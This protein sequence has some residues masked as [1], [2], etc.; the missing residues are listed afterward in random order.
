MPK[1]EQ[2]LERAVENHPDRK[3]LRECNV[4][5]HDSPA[6]TPYYVL[7]M[8]MKVF[9]HGENE[10][11]E[12]TRQ[13]HEE[14]KSVVYTTHRE[15]AELKVSQVQTYGADQA[16]IAAGIPCEGGMTATIEEV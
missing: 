4:I 16:A 3:P 6:H 12:M 14:G 7:D 9:K 13:V 2:V 8:L 11:K 10:A 15:F 5:L 1:N